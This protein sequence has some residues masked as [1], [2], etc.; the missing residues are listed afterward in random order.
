MPLLLAPSRSTETMHDTTESIHKSCCFGDES[1]TIDYDFPVI[2]PIRYK[3]GYRP[4]TLWE[5]ALHWW[6]GYGWITDLAVFE[7]IHF[8]EPGYEEACFEDSIVEC[9]DVQKIEVIR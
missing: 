1:E 4:A 7:A 2:H 9:P 5:K 8:G 3:I 6:K